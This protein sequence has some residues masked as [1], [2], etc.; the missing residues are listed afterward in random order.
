MKPAHKNLVYESL[1]ERARKFSWKGVLRDDGRF[2]GRVTQRR[3]ES[4]EGGK[5][6]SSKA[7]GV[8]QVLLRLTARDDDE[9]YWGGCPCTGARDTKGVQASKAEGRS[10]G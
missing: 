10:T 4:R 8:R 6:E 9:V 1:G 7:S 2:L 5:E 3:D